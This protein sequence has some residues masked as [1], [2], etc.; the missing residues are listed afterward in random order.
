MRRTR[1]GPQELTAAAV[2]ELGAVLADPAGFEDAITTHRAAALA[3][4]KVYGVSPDRPGIP[5][6]PGCLSALE[7]TKL[8]GEMPPGALGVFFTPPWWN[9]PEDAP[10]PV[11]LAADVVR[12]AGDVRQHQDLG[13]LDAMTEDALTLGECFNELLVALGVPDRAA[14][15]RAAADA[16]ER[17]R[18]LA[19]GRWGGDEGERDRDLREERIKAWNA[20]LREQ[21]PEL[22]AEKRAVTISKRAVSEG[23]T[24]KNGAPLSVSA[25]LSIIADRR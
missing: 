8:E 6:P 15:W 7:W 11:R 13:L 21:H 2:K 25:V 17:G 22:T 3:V 4:L 24:G 14:V 18:K 10:L 20:I 23:W 19:R 12:L 1:P 9:V 16:S 5:A